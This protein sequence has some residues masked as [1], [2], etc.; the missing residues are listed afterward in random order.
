VT[1][2][3]VRTQG[4]YRGLHRVLKARLAPVARR[5]RAKQMR[6]HLVTFVAEESL[7][8]KPHE[9]L[10]GSREVLE[11]V[12]GKLKHLKQDQAKSGFT[13]LVLSLAA[14]VSSTTTE[15]VQKALETVPTKKGLVWCKQTLGQSVQAKRRQAFA[16]HKKKEQK[17]DQFKGAV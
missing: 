5:S 15:V 2:H 1:G 8:A 11:S 4:G 10:L 3:V 9:R 6:A 7:K 14:I 13:G 17:R 12:F 16:S